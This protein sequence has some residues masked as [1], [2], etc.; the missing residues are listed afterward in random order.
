M[1]LNG[2]PRCVKR[3]YTSR[4]TY[5]A[6]STVSFQLECITLS[7]DVIPNPG[8]IIPQ[9]HHGDEFHIIPGNGLKIGQWNVNNLTD[10]KLEQVKLLLSPNEK[11]DLLFLIETFLTSKK[12]ASL[13]A[14]NGYNMIR[15]DG[16]GSQKGG[17]MVCLP[18]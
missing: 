17:G 14:I 4:I 11:I 5:Y 16:A 18:T 13:L 12:P 8:P 3:F 6:A 15:K 2:R 10:T 9:N 7:G 1:S